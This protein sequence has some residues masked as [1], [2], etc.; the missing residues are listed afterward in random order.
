MKSTKKYWKGL[1]Q[2]NNTP[3]FSKLAEKEF[4]EYLPINESDSEPSRRDFLKVMGFGIGAVSLAACEAPIR[5]A[6]PYVEK[7]VDVDPSIPN[8]YA[9]TF[10]DGSD[11][12]NVVVKTR[13]GRPIKVEGNELSAF[14]GGGTTSQVEASVLSLY[15]KQRL[16]GPMKDGK[17]T[18]WQDID[19]AVSALRG[20]NVAI[21]THSIASPSTQ[22]AIEQF[23]AGLGTADVVSYDQLSVSGVLDA[24]EATFG[25]RAYPSYDFSSADVIVSFGSDFLGSGANQ[26]LNNK[27]FAATRKLGDK[28]KTMSRLYA[29]ES[30]LSLTGANADYRFPVR[31]SEIPGL[32]ADLYDTIVNGATAKDDQVKKVAADLR[33][34]SGKALVVAG[35]NN[36]NVQ[37]LVNAINSTL[38]AYGST[39]D[40]N[41]VN[42]T[43]KG[44]DKAFAAFVNNLKGGR[45]NGVIFYNCNPVYD[46]PMGSE[47]AGALG[48]VSVSV[49]TSDRMDETANAVKMIAPD[50]HYLES[51]NDFELTTGTY[52][53][54][55]PT[56]SNI[57]DT[58]QAQESFLNWAGSETKN[59]Y[60]F[61]R[62][63]WE[64]VYTANPGAFGNFDQFWDKSLHDGVLETDAASEEVAYDG[65]SVAGAASAVKGMAAASGLELVLYVNSSV[66]NGRQ[67]NNPWLQE[68]PDPITKA[69]WDNYL[70]VSPKQAEEWGIQTDAGKMSTQKVNLTVNGQTL[71]VPVLPQPGQAYNTM[72]LALGYGRTNAGKVADGVGVNAYPLIQAAGTSL[73]Y[74]LTGVNAEATSESHN[75]AQTQTSQTFLG[76][77]NVVQESILK[78]YQKDAGAG[79]SHPHIAT[80]EGFKK[81]SAVS[82]WKGHKYANHHWGMA[83]DLNSCTGCGTCTIACQTENNI[84]VVGK[85]EVINRREMHWIRIDRYYSHDPEEL[86]D[87]QKGLLGTRHGEFAAYAN[88]EVTFQPM[89]CQQC[90]NAPCETVCPVAA[91]THSS[92]GLNQMTYNRCIGTRYCANNCPY[93]VRRF[94]WFKYHD[95]EQF[96]DNLA[97]NNDLGKMV[98]NP[99]VTVRA[100]GVM[101]K[102]TFCVQRIQAGKLEAKKENRRP[103]DGEVNVA[104]AKSC[105]S[106]AL[107]FGDMKDPESR[108]SKL[109]KIKSMDKGVE[110]QEERAYHVLEE[111][112]VMPNI[113]YLTKIRNKDEEK[114]SE[115]AA[116]THA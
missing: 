22:A 61:I 33:N 64:A 19:A 83:I 41:K 69:C 2:L 101:E 91:T 65:A 20:Q 107:V 12:S 45:Y 40:L 81:P 77:E 100:R 23:T 30:N 75:I 66:G 109:L 98:L 95:N 52:S 57:F 80:S 67:A 53:L 11:Y 92:E 34:A 59:Y 82:L 102:C 26:A 90:N 8:Y 108:I 78:A 93:K 42:N 84:P 86:T 37:I 13:E 15:D 113:W 47:I 76:R 32:I 18:T 106:D 111:L 28:K 29:F 72:G 27:Q 60:D 62:S 73:S 25:K 38:G 110:A 49:S 16:T 35:S 116:S 97:M 115:G 7:P 6:I 56:I 104:C 58:R 94:N 10:V 14:S 87:T 9:S 21:V 55:Q 3:S 46:H 105:P 63:N 71:A 79:R 103:V 54:A 96:G 44:D 99:D 1:E 114:K 39:I 5:N 74:E 36:T 88:P 112:R 85:Q 43:R 89:M 50:S 17:A 70:T 51:W 24:N 31:P 48:N 68:M 4:P